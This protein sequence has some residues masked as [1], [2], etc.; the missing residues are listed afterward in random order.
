MGIRVSLDDFGTGYSSLSYLKRFRFD[1][2]KIDRTFVRHTLQDSGNRALVENLVRLAK[3]LKL[4][5][6]AEGVE[7]AEQAAFLAAVGCDLAQ[8][9]HFARPAAADA[10]LPLL[11]TPPHRS[12]AA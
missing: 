12:P 7:T 10:V 8:G 6:V 5:V 9:F 3:A 11:T 1:I 4:T 2:L